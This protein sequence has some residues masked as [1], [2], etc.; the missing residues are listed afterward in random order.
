MKTRNFVILGLA[1]CLAFLFTNIEVLADSRKKVVDHHAVKKSVGGWSDRITLSGEVEVEAN[2]T[3]MNFNSPGAPDTAASDLVLEKVELSVDADIVKHVQGHITLEWEGSLVL[4]EGYILLDGLDK[5]PFYLS[6]GLMHVPFGYF[7]NHFIS[8]PITYQIGETMD[9][10]LMVGFR[11]D[12][13]DISGAVF[14]ANIEK[15]GQTDHVRSFAGRGILTFPAS[16][17]SGFG[18]MVGVS[19]TTSLDN[20]H[21][22]EHP[23]EHAMEHEGFDSLLDHVSGVSAFLSLSFMEKFAL[24]LEYLGALKAFQAGE[25]SFDGEVAA[26][27]KSWNLE[28]AY[29]L[30]DDLELAFRYE[31]SR[32]LGTY[33]PEKQYGAVLN[34]KVFKNTKLAFEYLHG[35]FQNNDK[36]SSFI[37]QLAVEF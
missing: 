36:R 24:E 18:L 34:W 22:F 30:T 8:K 29:A 32:D 13:I 12:W 7:E 31:G 4:E 28:L 23:I 11:N 3:D 10:A 2:Y 27:P 33:M 16:D 1:I 37:A 5:T 21:G 17:T 6:A 9:S 35:T 26:Q 20:S 25:L 14:N 15:T 19:F